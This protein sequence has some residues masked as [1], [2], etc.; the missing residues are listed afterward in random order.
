MSKLKD[1]AKYICEGTIKHSPEILSG[2]SIVGMGTAIVFSVK[3]TPK[4]VKLIDE[5]KKELNT[6]NIDTKEIVKTTWKCYIPTTAMF[7]ASAGCLIAS[8]KIS[9]RRCTAFATAYKISEAALTEYQNKVIETIGEKKEKEIHT[10]IAK[11]HIDNNPVKNNEIII[12]GS[13]DVR[14]YE[15]VSGRYFNSDIEKIR[16]VVND[17]NKRLLIENYISLNEF[18][19]ELGLRPTDV[20]ND[21]GWNV[22]DGLIEINFSSHLDDDN[23]PC[24][25]L[26]YHVSPRYDFRRLY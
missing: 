5:R 7:I 21:L 10:K 18:Y 1:F 11:D 6:D 22:E 19:Y 4:A 24:L 3:A 16:K 25:V 23:K 2:M 15:I 17:L 8:H 12:T 9:A 13:G 20:G 14:C 26:D